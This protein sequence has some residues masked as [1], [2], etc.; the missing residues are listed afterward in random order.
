MLLCILKSTR[1]VPDLPDFTD[2]PKCTSAVDRSDP[3]CFLYELAKY[4]RII[5]Q[6]H[7]PSNHCVQ[8]TRYKIQDTFAQEHH[9]IALSGLTTMNFLSIY[10]LSFSLK[11]HIIIVFKRVLRLHRNF[12][13][14]HYISGR[15]IMVLFDVEHTVE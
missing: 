8:D 1:V 14:Y 12:K 2:N 4:L 10:V 5:I 13:T 3:C 6:P 7:I 11:F 9:K 15:F